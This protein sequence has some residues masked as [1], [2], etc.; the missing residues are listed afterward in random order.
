MQGSDVETVLSY[1]IQGMLI[2]GSLCMLSTDA[3]FPDCLLGQ[4]IEF[5]AL[6][7]A[8]TQSTTEQ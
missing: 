5:R 8:D 7:L 1:S 4:G 2:L 6:H 3:T